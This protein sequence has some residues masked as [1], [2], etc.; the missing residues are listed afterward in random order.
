[1]GY[2]VDSRNKDLG[3]LRAAKREGEVSDHVTTTVNVALMEESSVKKIR[4]TSDVVRHY[5]GG[6]NT[7]AL[8]ETKD[9]R[10]DV[11]TILDTCGAKSARGQGRQVATL[12]LLEP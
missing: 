8:G 3:L 5:N 2:T 9:A 4:V 7:Q 10:A 6:R 12:Q 1:M 11:Q